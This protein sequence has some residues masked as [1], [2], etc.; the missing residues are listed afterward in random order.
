MNFWSE[1]PF[2]ISYILMP[3][4]TFCLAEAGAQLVFDWHWHSISQTE[5]PRSQRLGWAVT[6]HLWLSIAFVLAMINILARSYMP[7]GYFAAGLFWLA[8]LAIAIFATWIWVVRRKANPSAV[9]VGALLFAM[10]FAFAL[11]G[12]SIFILF[13]AFGRYQPTEAEQRWPLL[14]VGVVT[15]NVLPDLLVLLP[16][17][18][19]DTGDLDALRPFKFNWHKEPA[20]RQQPTAAEN[21]ELRHSTPQPRW[22]TGPA[23]VPAQAQDRPYHY[24]PGGV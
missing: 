20:P 3:G 5:I 4:A 8:A 13:L 12:Q 21:F 23:V 16:A 18:A 19:F 10:A 14:E 11:A 24:H 1:V 17:I 9:G 15:L 2:W 22:S 6:R 7:I